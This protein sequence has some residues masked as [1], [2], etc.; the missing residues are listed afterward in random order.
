M[1]RAS[2][3]FSVFVLAVFALAAQSEAQNKDAG[4]TLDGIKMTDINCTN[5]S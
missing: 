4:K 1:K 2:I 5:Q 3:L